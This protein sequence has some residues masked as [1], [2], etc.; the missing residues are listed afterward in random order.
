MLCSFLEL[1]FLIVIDVRTLAF[2]EPLYEK[3]FGSASKKNNS[4]VS[5]RSS[6]SGPGDPLFDDLSAEVSVN[7][8]FLRPSYSLTQSRVSNRFLPGKALEPPGL[9]D[10]H[11][12]PDFI[13]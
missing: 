7:L 10:S 8:A 2:G 13:L 4:T 1:C 3:R 6:L 5:F 12:K 11:T 9:E